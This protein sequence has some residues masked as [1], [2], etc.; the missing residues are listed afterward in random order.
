MV[1][2]GLWAAM[3]GGRSVWLVPAA[4]LVADGGRRRAGCRRFRTAGGRDGH[5]AVRWSPW[6]RWWRRRRRCLPRLGWRWSAPSPCSTAMP[7]GAEMPIADDGLA[8]GPRLPGGD[9][10]AAR[11]GRRPWARSPG[12]FRRSGCCAPAGG[13]IAAGGAGAAGGVGRRSASIEGKADGRP[14][15]PLPADGGGPSGFPPTL[16]P[17]LRFSCWQAGAFAAKA[18]QLR[19]A[20]SMKVSY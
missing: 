2:V 9:G 17:D 1:A 20:P 14:P 8:Y 13:A 19:C 15:A 11:A 3:A 7:T 10:G 18:L 5:R 6:A 12:V 4:F 16:Q